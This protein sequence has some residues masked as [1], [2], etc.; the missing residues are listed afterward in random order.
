VALLQ[1][2]VGGWVPTLV[3]WAPAAHLPLSVMCVGRCFIG[4]M[5][6]GMFGM[7]DDG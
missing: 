5:I 4:E 1:T 3:A 2:A 7:D 6:S